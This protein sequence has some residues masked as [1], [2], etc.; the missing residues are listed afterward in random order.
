MLLLNKKNVKYHYFNKKAIKKSIKKVKKYTL[1]VL[2]IIF[3]YG[4]LYLV[5]EIWG[6]S[7][8]LQHKSLIEDKTKYRKQVNVRFTM[9]IIV[10]SFFVT[11][12]H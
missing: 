2:T 8:L 4:I 6:P 3:H 7:L 1:K 11:I 9:F 12:K 10:L 5:K